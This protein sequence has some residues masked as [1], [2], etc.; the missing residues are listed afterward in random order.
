VLETIVAVFAEGVTMRWKFARPSC[1]V[2]KTMLRQTL[3][4]APQT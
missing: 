4:A 3:A 2:T 1:A